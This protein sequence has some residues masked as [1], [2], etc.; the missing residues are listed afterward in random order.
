MVIDSNLEKEFESRVWLTKNQKQT[1]FSIFLQKSTLKGKSITG[2]IFTCEIISGSHCD[3][4]HPIQSIECSFGLCC[5]VPFDAISIAA[6]VATLSLIF[7]C[8]YAKFSTMPMNSCMQTVF[9]FAITLRFSHVVIKNRNLSWSNQMV[10]LLC[11]FV[12]SIL[13]TYRLH[14]WQRS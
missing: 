5:F 6:A 14:R 1:F 11:F 8:A 9:T 4:L 10:W 7:R 13:P 2:D 12:L 3:I